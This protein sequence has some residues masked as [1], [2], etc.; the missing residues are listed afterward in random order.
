V[1][2]AFPTTRPITLDVELGAGLLT[3]R[4]GDGDETVVAVEGPGAER[5]AVDRHGDRI[6]I[7]QPV[8][9]ALLAAEAPT[10]AVTCPPDSRVVARLGRAGVVATGRLGS[11]RVRTGSGDV[12]IDELGAEAAIDCGSGDIL[13]SRA[14]GPA[15]LRT[16]S[17]RVVLEEAA[18]PLVATSGSGGVTVG[19][20]AASAVLK[21]GSGPVGVRDA[22]TD[23]S[24]A[25]G[26]GDITLGQVR[27]G[28][29]TART[30]SGDVGVGVP[31]GVPVWT[32]ITTVSGSIHSTLLG[33][34]RPEP[35]QDHVELR[36][37][38]VSGD[39]HLTQLAAHQP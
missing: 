12:R 29:V 11:V 28:R 18:G 27:R 19:T 32:D 13:V 34:G 17:G 39:V 20:T 14:R 25:T 10:V 38:T 31:P 22:A 1:Q 23:V 36:I 2:T 3:I 26:S 30:A 7:A 33:A 4:A 5:V 16:G 8:G 15:R 6:S 21:S 37:R 35:G 9:R 24:L